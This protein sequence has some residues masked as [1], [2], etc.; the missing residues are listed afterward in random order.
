MLK[1]YQIP[2]N[3]VLTD[4]LMVVQLTKKY[5]ALYKTQKV[6]FHDHDTPPLFPILSYVHMLCLSSS[7]GSMSLQQK[8]EGLHTFV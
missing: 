7:K 5:S 2:N 1:K 6:N 8:L 4:D 3:R